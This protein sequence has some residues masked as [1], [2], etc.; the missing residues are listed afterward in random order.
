MIDVFGVNVKLD[1]NLCQI[2]CLANAYVLRSIH[3]A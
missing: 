3:A 1:K 2:Y